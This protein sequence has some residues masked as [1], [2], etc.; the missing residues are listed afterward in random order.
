MPAVTRTR[1]NRAIT[2]AAKAAPPRLVASAQ[3]SSAN[4][5]RQVKPAEKSMIID[6][7]AAVEESAARKRRK[8]ET[9]TEEKQA[10]VISSQQPM[11]TSDGPTHHYRPSTLPVEPKF[12]VQAAMDHLTGFD[13]RFKGLFSAMKCRPFVEPFQAVDPFRTLATSIVG[14]QVNHVDR[15]PGGSSLT[16]YSGQLDGS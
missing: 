8:V 14:Q 16:M 1:A 2:S 15:K 12:S 10:S 7:R 5:R 4:G 9:K 11:T 13:P 3:A 6:S